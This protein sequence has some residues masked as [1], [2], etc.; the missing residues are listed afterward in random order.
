MIIRAG[1]IKRNLQKCEL[2]SQ[3]EITNIDECKWDFFMNMIKSPKFSCEMKCCIENAC[4]DIVND[5]EIES[6]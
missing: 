3:S 4:C 5:L 6:M 2:N 1:F